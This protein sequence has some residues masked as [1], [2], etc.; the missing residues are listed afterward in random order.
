MST[1]TVSTLER[2]ELLNHRAERTARAHD[3]PRASETPNS[4][5]NAW[6]ISS[7]AAAVDS[8]DPCYLSTCCFRGLKF[9]CIR[10]TPMSKL[11]SREKFFECFASRGA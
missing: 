4:S 8:C 2:L 10:S 5:M 11:S 3:A 7:F 9:L 1:A 6:Q